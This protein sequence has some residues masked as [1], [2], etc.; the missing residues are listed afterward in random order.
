MQQWDEVQKL[1]NEFQRLQ[2]TASANRLSE[3]NCI[4]LVSRL[5]DGGQIDVLYT[6]D[7]REYVTQQHLEKEIRNELLVH[8]G[9]LVD[10]H[11]HHVL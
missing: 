3:R 7:G 11:L 10:L 9:T 2:A 5:V 6:L 4:E 8:R 1:A